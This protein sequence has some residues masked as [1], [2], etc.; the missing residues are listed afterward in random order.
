M[1]FL[2]SQRW[3]SFFLCAI[4]LHFCQNP[5]LSHTFVLGDFI[6]AILLMEIVTKA[7]NLKLKVYSTSVWVMFAKIPSAQLCLRKSF[8]KLA[9]ILYSSVGTKRLPTE[10]WGKEIRKFSCL[11]LLKIQNITSPFSFKAGLLLL[12]K[13]LSNIFH[14]DR[15]CWKQQQKMIQC[16]IWIAK[17]RFQPK[18]KMFFAWWV[19]YSVNPWMRSMGKKYCGPQ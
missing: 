9:V 6:T 13:S 4:D 8:F 14:V 15:T 12:D 17:I 7:L 3:C 16:G 2:C 18:C 1:Y 5:S 10:K 11:F 19:V